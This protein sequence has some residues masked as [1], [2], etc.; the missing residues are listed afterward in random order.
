[1]GVYLFRRILREGHDHRFTKIRIN[2]R[3]YLR[4][5]IG[6]ATWVTFC[7]LPIIAINAIPSGVPSVQEPKLADFFGFGLWVV[8]FVLEVVADYQKSK[9]QQE[10]QDKIHDE[11]FLTSGLWS[12]WY[13]IDFL[14]PHPLSLLLI[15]VYHSQFPNYFGESMLWVGIA[16]VTL[17]I[18]LQGD[19]RKSL[20]ATNSSPMSIISVVF[21]CTVGPAFVTF[22]MLKVTG[23]PYAERKYNK[24]YGEDREYKKWKK[25]T[26]K[27]FP[28]PSKYF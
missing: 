23:V 8:G 12:E 5:F 14:L 18:L 1:M 15:Q 6:Q 3:R 13:V 7:L 4:A 24:L 9:W 2:P 21:F 10:K 11:K 16:T 27:F 25:D 17:N 19:A 26:P 28:I 22:L 20:S